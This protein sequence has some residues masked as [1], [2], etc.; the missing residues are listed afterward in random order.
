MQVW[1]ESPPRSG[2]VLQVRARFP[3]CFLPPATAAP[4]LLVRAAATVRWIF[5]GGVFCLHGSCWLSGLLVLP[6]A[7]AW[8]TLELLQFPRSLHLQ[9]LP[10]DIL[11]PSR[12]W[13]PLRVPL[14]CPGR[15]RASPGVGLPEGV[16]FPLPALLPPPASASPV[17]WPCSPLL[18]QFLSQ[19]GT[20]P[21]PSLGQ[22]RL[23]AE[24]GSGRP[25]RSLST[26]PG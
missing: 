16:S 23:G 5:F 15:L 25:R 26:E 10:R 20:S 14:A 19:A 7:C 21:F 18:G 17:Q 11:L 1:Q 6:R 8:G 24:G 22:K 3:L 13:H 4:G 9:L 12:A 2:F